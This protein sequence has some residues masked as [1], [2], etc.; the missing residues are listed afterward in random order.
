MATQ[1]V[2][3]VPCLLRHFPLANTLHIH[4][5]YNF[6]EEYILRFLKT[7]PFKNLK[8][9]HTLQDRPDYDNLSFP[10]LCA[11]E[12]EIIR[13]CQRDSKVCGRANLLRRCAYIAYSHSEEASKAVYQ[14]VLQSIE[15]G[16]KRW[17]S[18][19][20]YVEQ[21]VLSGY[22]ARARPSKA[23]QGTPG[24]STT[25]YAALG[26]PQPKSPKGLQKQYSFASHSRWASVRRLGRYIEGLL[27]AR[28]GIQSR[29]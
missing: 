7:P 16:D 28:M 1:L 22:P 9:E 24:K 20:N 14:A 23:A 6:W 2:A 29:R 15:T 17:S 25:P 8:F 12:L 5:G 18:N 11:G 26:G 10:L 13:R 19:F 3:E 21:S 4:T 27:R